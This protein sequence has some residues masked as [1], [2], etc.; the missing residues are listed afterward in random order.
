MESDKNAE[1]LDELIERLEHLKEA[2]KKVQDAALNLSLSKEQKKMVRPNPHIPIT[3]P[4][5]RKSEM[6]TKLTEYQNQKITDTLC[7]MSLDGT[8]HEE[9]NLANEE[10]INACVLLNK[11]TC[12]AAVTENSSQC[13]AI[14]KPPFSISFENSG[15]IT[16]SE[17]G[18]IEISG[19]CVVSSESVLLTA[20]NFQRSDVRKG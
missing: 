12:G 14:I 19:G 1:A 8:G 15:E 10:L 20:C 6:N 17:N 13:L 16:I 9:I 3:D 5:M 4:P 11:F 2:F 18:D 7:K